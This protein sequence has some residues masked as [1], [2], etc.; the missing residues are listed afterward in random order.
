M[1]LSMGL[2]STTVTT[3]VSVG[4]LWLGVT[5]PNIA[6]HLLLVFFYGSSE[7]DPIEA[8]LADYVEKALKL[9]AEGISFE[10]SIY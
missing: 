4:L 9:Q 6:N 2:E 8:Y 1:F 7:P 5:F 10:G 3:H